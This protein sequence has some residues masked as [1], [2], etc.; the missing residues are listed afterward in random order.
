M[1][2]SFFNNIQ[3]HFKLLSTPARLNY[4]PTRRATQQNVGR[5][6]E[7]FAVSS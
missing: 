5:R 2:P 3:Q 6:L 7:V 4:G 1:K